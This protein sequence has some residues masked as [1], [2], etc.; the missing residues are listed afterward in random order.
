MASYGPKTWTNP[1]LLY[2]VTGPGLLVV[3]D[4]RVEGIGI[5]HQYPLVITYN[6]SLL[7]PQS[8]PVTF[9][10]IPKIFRSILPFNSH[11]T[12]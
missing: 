4:M 12:P 1:E 6:F 11:H 7:Y 8:I 5:V 9:T 10:R 3:F 2:Y